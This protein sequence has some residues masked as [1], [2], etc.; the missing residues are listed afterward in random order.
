MINSNHALI[1]KR[2][3]LQKFEERVKWFYNTITRRLKKQNRPRKCWK[4]LDGTYNC[5]HRTLQTL[6][7][8][9]FNFCATMGQALAEQH[10]TN[11]GEVGKC[12]D[13][14]FC[15]KDIFF[16][17]ASINCRKNGYDINNQ[18]AT[19]YIQLNK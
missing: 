14:W 10:F 12:L 1:E 17:M 5:T 3:E 9:T 7:P 6:P 19:T 4:H 18:V 2:P 8:P 15:S 16:G 11:L 13:A